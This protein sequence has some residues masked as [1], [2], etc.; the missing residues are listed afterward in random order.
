MNNTQRQSTSHSVMG[1]ASGMSHYKSYDAEYNQ[2]NIQKPYENRMAT[3]NM[4]L[5]N[6]NINAS[7]N[8]HEQC[9]V[10]TNALY[11]PSNDTPNTNVLGQFTKQNQKYELPTIDNSILKA[12]K[13]NPYTHSLSSVA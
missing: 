2:R 3:G 6:G 11:A 13:E 12:F 1:G 8:G 4:S 5:Y 7:I 9:N 10:R